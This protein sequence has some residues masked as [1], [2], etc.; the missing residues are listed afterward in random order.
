[1]KGTGAA[2]TGKKRPR[3]SIDG[4]MASLTVRKSHA[5]F[6]PPGENLIKHEDGPRSITAILFLPHSAVCLESRPQVIKPFVPRRPILRPRSFPFR[7]CSRFGA[8][9]RSHQTQKL[10]SPRLNFNSERAGDAPRSPGL[11]SLPRGSLD[12]IG[13]N[14]PTPS[15]RHCLRPRIETSD[16]PYPPDASK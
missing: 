8:P 16:R 6:I 5:P 9:R 13:D 12:S 15:E 1:M 2:Q 7:L 10:N 14:S 4:R 11:S 3:R